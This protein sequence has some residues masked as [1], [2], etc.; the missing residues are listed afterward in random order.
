MCMYFCNHR[1]IVK[2]VN[3]RLGSTNQNHAW[4]IFLKIPRS[5]NLRFL[6]YFH[7]YHCDCQLI[8]HTP[9][10]CTPKSSKHHLIIKRSK[11]KRKQAGNKLNSCKS[12]LPG[13]SRDFYFT[14]VNISTSIIKAPARLA[15]IHNIEKSVVLQLRLLKKS[16]PP[17]LVT[18]YD[19][20][21]TTR[22]IYVSVCF[23]CIKIEYRLSSL[24]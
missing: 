18:E 14:P 11:K 16:L 17:A 19:K 6:I 20:Q 9:I 8:P 2:I 5:F 3:G 21:E 4:T 1:Q 15:D 7:P 22:A 13:V 24:S 10:H 23:N 12:W